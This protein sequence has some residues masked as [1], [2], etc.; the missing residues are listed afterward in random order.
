LYWDQEITEKNCVLYEK[1]DKYSNSYN[2]ASCNNV[3]PRAKLDIRCIRNP[4][5]MT[6][7]NVLRLC[8]DWWEVYGAVSGALGNDNI[9][10]IKRKVWTKRITTS[11]SWDLEALTMAL[12][13]SYVVQKTEK[14]WEKSAY[15]FFVEI[16]AS[17]FND[18]FFMWKNN[19]HF[20]PT[21]RNFSAF[22]FLFL[23]FFSLFFSLFRCLFPSYIWNYIF[24]TSY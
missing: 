9:K 4:I 2:I 11:W 18:T 5:K 23:F 12:A 21:F 14:K 1:T 24:K 15:A 7:N 20:I 16:F 3:F 13:F 22:F 17:H 6:L 19:F 8:F 10:K